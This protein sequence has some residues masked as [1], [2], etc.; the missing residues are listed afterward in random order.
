[1]RIVI[2]TWVSW[3]WK[4]TLQESL[5]KKGWKRPINFTTR[6]PRNENEVDEYVFLNKEQFVKKL[7]NWDFLEFT[8]YNWNFYGV[9]NTLTEDAN[10]CIILDPIWRAQ[11][12]NTLSYKGISYETF[13]IDIDPEEQ[14]KRLRKRGDTEE[15]IKLRLNDFKWFHPTPGCVL[16][17]W[18]TKVETNVSCIINNK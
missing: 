5:L 3:S 14:L 16:L 9:S 7:I 17:N 10:Y 18:E 15:Q 4:T 13:Y 12:M 1:M 8:Q 11:V 6:K 2:I